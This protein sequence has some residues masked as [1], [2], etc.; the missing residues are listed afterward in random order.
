M[1]FSQ[2]ER[3][4]MTIILIITTIL[5]ILFRF[6]KENN[7]RTFGAVFGIWNAAWILAV[8]I[9]GLITRR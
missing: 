6:S 8:M 4:V 9:Y 3:I 7:Y 1:Y 5:G 2:G